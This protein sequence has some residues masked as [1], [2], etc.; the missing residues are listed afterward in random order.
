MIVAKLGH[1]DGVRTLVNHQT[2]VNY[3]SENGSTPLFEAC[4]TNQIDVVSFLLLHGAKFNLSDPLAAS[5]MCQACIEEN[6]KLAK[7][8]KQGTQIFPPMYSDFLNYP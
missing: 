7:I 4:K 3:C 5:I 1:L 8:L 2:D 6:L